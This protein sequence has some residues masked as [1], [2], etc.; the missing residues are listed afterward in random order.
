MIQRAPYLIAYATY[1]AAEIHVRVSL[2]YPD[3]PEAHE[4]LRTC[5]GVL[6]ENQLTNSMVVSATRSL[7]DMMK[8]AG[9]S[10]QDDPNVPF[11]NKVQE[12]RITGRFGG[13]GRESFDSTFSPLDDFNIDA[14]L[15]TYTDSPNIGFL[16]T[17]RG[18]GRY[19]CPAFP[20]NARASTSILTDPP[21]L[22]YDSIAVKG[23]Q[24]KAETYTPTN[25]SSDYG[26]SS[27]YGSSFSPYNASRP[28]IGESRP[29]KELL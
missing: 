7:A 26:G 1:V 17:E 22:E 16:G 4:C 5:L 15:Q 9:V 8:Q 25:N 21:I 6:N 10:L 28:G 29:N 19:A 11:R 2:Q 27:A 13:T 24:D 18:Q 23:D 3:S 14:I 20:S 12:P